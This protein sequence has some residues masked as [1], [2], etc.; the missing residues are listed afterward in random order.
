MQL[1]I[2]HAI[3]EAAAAVDIVHEIVGASGIRDEYSFSRHFRDIHVITQ[4]GFINSA[5][6]QPVGQI[7]L[8][9]AP[10]WPFFAF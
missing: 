2:T 5:K 7:M 6:L 1:A 8:G 3:L 9:L 4:H 10:D